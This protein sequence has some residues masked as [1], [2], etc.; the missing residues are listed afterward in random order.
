MQ[1]VNLLPALAVIAYTLAMFGCLRL[2]RWWMDY[3][4]AKRVAEFHAQCLLA[5]AESIRAGKLR[6]QEREWGRGA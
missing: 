1:T 3:R 5:E 4:D 2:L 6:A